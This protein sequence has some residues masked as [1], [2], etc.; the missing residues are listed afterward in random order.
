MVSAARTLYSS[1]VESTSI[2]EPTAEPWTVARDMRWKAVRGLVVDPIALLGTAVCAWALVRTG[3]VGTVAALLALTALATTLADDLLFGRP[4]GDLL[5]VQPLGPSGYLRVRAAELGWWMKLPA[6]LA[7]AAAVGVAGAGAGAAALVAAWLVPPLG[8]RLAL[9]LRATF[10]RHGTLLVWLPAAVALA[11]PLPHEAW[12]AAPFAAAGLLAKVGL[13]RAF[14]ARFD[15]LASDAATAPRRRWA[16]AWPLMSAL[17]APLPAPLRAR[18]VRDVT[19]LVRGRDP[20]GLVLLAL[21]PLSCLLLRDELATLPM[22]AAMPWRV[23]TCAAL[24][25]AAVAYAVGPG[26]HRVRIGAMAWERVAPKPGR[27]AV[28]GALAYALPLALLHGGATLATLALVQDGR[29][30]P[31]VGGLALPVLG[32]EASLAWFVVAFVLGAQSGRRILGEGTLTLALPVVGVGVAI[33]GV[34]MPALVPAF[35]ILTAPMLAT[36]ARRFERVEVTW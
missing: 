29:F 14:G 28:A 21:S 13:E 8:L 4:D 16:I 3:A 23:L 24:G 6:L 2:V 26:L 20:Q 31:D 19:L 17:A 18:V 9:A 35:F 30:A 15:R 10:G 25:G 36:A 1:G 32:L 7:A 22:R 5:R 27:R 34:L 11:A 33:A 12:T